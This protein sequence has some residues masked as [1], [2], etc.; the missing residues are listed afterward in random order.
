MCRL[1]SFMKQVAPSAMF[2]HFYIIR[3]SVAMC[4]CN[5]KELLQLMK[6]WIWGSADM[7][8]PPSILSMQEHLT[9]CEYLMLTVWP[10]LTN[11]M[12]PLP[13]G[14]A[15]ERPLNHRQLGGG[16]NFLEHA[17]LRSV[18]AEFLKLTAVA[19]EDNFTQAHP[20][21]RLSSLVNTTWTPPPPPPTPA[22][23]PR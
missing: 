18:A 13:E 22:A 12:A 10:K 3:G 8:P 23:C 21:M 9:S 19:T 5:P 7:T 4:P 15:Q 17:A 11:Q 20:E 6:C 14:L 2:C 16:D 1:L